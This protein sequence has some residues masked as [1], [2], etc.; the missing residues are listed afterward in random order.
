MN[1]N[2]ID[3]KQEIANA[4]AH[5]FY[6]A[7]SSAYYIPVFLTHKEEAELSVPNFATGGVNSTTTQSLRWMNSF[8]P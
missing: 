5:H 8:L 4:I 3:N 1:N 7:S 6:Q 2:I